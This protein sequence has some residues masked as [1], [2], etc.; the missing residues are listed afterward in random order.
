MKT[1][2]ESLWKSDDDI[3][4]KYDLSVFDKYK[5]SSTLTLQ[6]LDIQNETIINRRID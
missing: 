3:T 1:F 2:K 6:E 4:V 5:D